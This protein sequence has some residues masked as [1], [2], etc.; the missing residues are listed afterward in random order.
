MDGLPCTCRRIFYLEHC[1]RT[2]HD[3]TAPKG[4]RHPRRPWLLLDCFPP[5][6]PMPLS[7]ITEARTSGVVVVVV[8]GACADAG[9]EVV[10]PL[11][12]A[13]HGPLG[14]LHL[15]PHSTST[16]T[17][18]PRQTLHAPPPPLPRWPCRQSCR[19]IYVYS[20]LAYLEV[21]LGAVSAVAGPEVR[22]EGPCTPRPQVQRQVVAAPVQH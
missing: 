11:R 8:P 21:V 10:P 17:H 6:L 3:N 22:G 5:H 14:V 4:V 18:M 7:Y 12:Q 20:V 2:T 9:R 1:T 16:H 15:T 13:E 19:H